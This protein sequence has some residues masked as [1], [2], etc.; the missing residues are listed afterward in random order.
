MAFDAK[1]IRIGGLWR[2]EGKNG[3]YL[4]GPFTNGT[5]IWIFPVNEKRGETSPD[6]VMYLS[7]QQDRGGRGGGGGG[8]RGGGSQRQQRSDPRDGFEDEP[9]GREPGE[10][11]PDDDEPPPI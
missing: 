11:S 3:R 5:V 8:Q 2:R 1:R 4:Y 10:D 7:E 9:G 6:Y